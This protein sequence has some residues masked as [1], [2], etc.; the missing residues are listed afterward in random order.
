[1][2]LSIFGF[3][4]CPGASLELNGYHLF[5]KMVILIRLIPGRTQVDI[6]KVE[7]QGFACAQDTASQLRCKMN[8]ARC[9]NVKGWF[10]L[11]IRHT[12]W[13]NFVEHERVRNFTDCQILRVFNCDNG[14]NRWQPSLLSRPI[15]WR[16]PLKL[17]EMPV[18]STWPWS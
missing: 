3:K 13:E 2:F 12:S 8:C 6:V 10:C 4:V 17:K 5:S 14:A 15:P 7:M 9:C 16:K 18:A 1:M 11:F